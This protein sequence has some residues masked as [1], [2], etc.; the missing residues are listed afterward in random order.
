MDAISKNSRDIEI[1]RELAKKYMEIATCDKNAERA[2]RGRLTG[3]LKPVRPLVW[4][5]EIPWPEMDI[6]GQLTLSCEGKAERAMERFFRRTL[7]R[8][9]YFQA[10]M[11]V[12]SFYAIQKSYDYSGFGISIKEN[13]QTSGVS[14]IVSHRYEDQLETFEKIDQ[15]H[16]PVITARPDVDNARLAWAEEILSGIMPARLRGTCFYFGPWDIISQLRGVEPILTD[17]VDR[18]EL[19]HKTM[20]K[21]MEIG[22]SQC[23]QMEAQNLL[24]WDIADLHCTPHWADGIPT[25]DYSGGAVRMKDVWYRGMAQMFSSVSPGMFE[26]FELSHTLPLME[27]F[28]AVYYGC[29]E[30]L[31]NKIH[32]LKKIPNLRKIGVSPWANPR[33][34][35]EQ[36]GQSYVFSHKPNPAH[37]AGSFNPDVVRAEIANVIEVCLEYK[38][39]YEFTLKDISTV[40]G[41]PGNLIEWCRVA[42]DTVSRFY[43]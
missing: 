14:E 12:E 24:D 17:M 43:D 36:I 35:A 29:C 6:D 15:L 33:R 1:L 11:V 32:I 2:Q 20:D 19:L 31:D 5:D 18:P 9:R 30:P 4:I 37:V 39:P 38:C 28:G 41:K 42:M 26:E 8:W 25:S 22:F 40:S 21:F 10:D 27:K 3:G 7:F 23:E 34:A 13:T 16:T